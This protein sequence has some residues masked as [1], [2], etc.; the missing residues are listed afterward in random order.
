MSEKKPLT[1]FQYILYGAILTT[2]VVVFMAQELSTKIE[3][4]PD[5]TMKAVWIGVFLGSI[6]GYFYGKKKLDG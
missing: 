6:G 4:S 1:M 3:S 5:K 2:M